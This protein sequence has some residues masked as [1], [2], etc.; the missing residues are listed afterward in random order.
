MINDSINK[1]SVYYPSAG[2]PGTPPLIHGI[3]ICTCKSAAWSLFFYIYSRI[4]TRL[5]MIRR[6]S[7]YV[8]LILFIILMAICPALRAQSE[9]RRYIKKI[10]SEH[11]LSHNIVNDIVQ[12]GKGFIW[13]ATDDGLNLFD[14]YEFKTYRFDPADSTS[15]LGNYIKSLF[16]D[17]KENLWISTRYGLNRYDPQRDI[18]LSFA[19]DWDGELDVT[20]ICASKDGGLWV[21][22]YTGGILYFNPGDG[23]FIDY[24]S[25]DP[26]FPANLTLAVHEDHEAYL[27]VGTGDDGLH[28]YR[29]N[30]GKLEA[31]KEFADKLNNLRINQVETI[32]EDTYG[33]IWIASRQGILFYHRTLHEFFHL[34]KSHGP[35]GLSGNIILD[36]NQDYMGNILI[37]TQEGGLNVLS[38]DQ[39]KANHPRAFR[40]LKILPGPED[41]HLSY[42]SV[43]TI[44]EDKDRNLWLGTFGNGI[45]L[46]PRI[47]PRFSLLKHNDLNPNSLNFDK[48][49]GLC[50]DKEGNLWIGTDGMGLNKYNLNT[51]EVTHYRAGGD[52]GDISDDAILS[53]LCDIKGRLWFGTYAGGLNLYQKETDSFTHIPLKDEAGGV[54]VNDIRAVYESEGGEIWVGSNGAGVIRF[55]ADDFSFENLVLSSGGILANDIRAITEDRE[56]GLWFGTYGTGL[57]YYHPGTKEI[58]HFAYDRVNPGTLKCNIIYALL[59]DE[60]KNQLWIGGSQNGGLNRLDLDHLTFSV[61]DHNMGLANN[62]IHAIE[63]DRRGRLWMSTNTG[64]TLFNPEDQEFTN[65]DKLDGV[66]EKEFSNGSAMRSTLH[67]LIFFGGSAG[68]NYFNADE[69]EKKDNEVPV[70]ITELKIFNESVPVRSEKKSESP[71][72]NT[73]QYTTDLKLNHRQN[74]ITIGFAGL[75]FSNPGKIKYQYTLEHADQEWKNLELQRNVTFQ[76]LRAGEYQL[77]VRAS[78]E[79]G[80]WSDGY[81]SLN[82]TI[83]PPPWRSWWAFSL[84]GLILLSFV[85]WI[86]YYNLKEA[87][88]RHKLL[89]EKKLRAQEHDLYEERI[90]FFTNISHELRTPLMLLINPLEELMTRESI[91]TVLGHKLNIMYRSANSL[92]QMIN[93][94]LEFRK[95]ETGKQKLSAA[96]YN[97]VELVEENSIAFRGMSA[98]K[99]IDI[100]FSSDDKI[101]ETWVDPEKMEMILNN[102]L[103]NAIKN[104]FENSCIYVELKK[105]QD[106]SPES[107]CGRVCIMIRDEG[108][109]IPEEE[110]DK[111]FDRFYQIK[112]AN[113]PGGT[114]IGLALTKRLVELHKGTIKVES[115]VN[116]GTTFFIW[117]PL[118][119]DHFSEEELSSG[120]QETTTVMSAYLDRQYVDTVSMLLEKLSSLSP[121]R[122]KIL[123]IED[124]EEIRDYL[125][126]LLKDRF[127]IEEAPDG[128]TGLEKARQILPALII[129]DIMMP[130]M[131]GLELCRKLKSEIETSH[132]PILMITANLA[133][134]VHIN[135]FEVGADAFITKPFKPDLLLSRIYNLLKSRKKL[136]E[137]Y[138]NQF[139]SGAVLENRSLNKDEEF[140]VRVKGLIHQHLNNSDFSIGLLHESLGMSR[141]VFYNKIRSLTN[142]APIDLVRHIRLR[143]AAEL[144]ST[145]EYKVF[146]AM[147]EVGFNDE[148][149]FRQLFKKQFGVVPSEYHK[150]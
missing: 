100:V 7:P 50:E 22:N 63:K 24:N 92:M 65:Y 140:L 52:P 93:T 29:N 66:Q 110:I 16:V 121:D 61:F 130:E 97:L 84:Y 129:S 44:Y 49:W 10:N 90:R 118:G 19:P 89:L 42:R 128:I 25:G 102:V 123:V 47:P 62:I 127:I 32:F 111:V 23:S 71:L 135:S 87:K 11:G 101:I 39:L 95:T 17:E 70:I 18:F 125:S 131:D 115:E 108:K 31:C 35:E 142:L 54:K 117:L 59:Y 126:D 80:V 2:F 85:L 5:S 74:N 41:F 1:G 55:N 109:G 134:H 149:H 82:I 53:A 145:G 12:D 137:Y 148:K 69:I 83:K 104:S 64:I 68:L 81:A 40:F 28:V 143:R 124:N 107:P 72:L 57:F 103:A 8:Y 27:W 116:Q 34:Q 132:I 94:L 15:I 141:T 98:R 91:N 73:I 56:G 105:E 38:Q 43:Q 13:I 58:R 20:D 144:L 46:I 30:E 96:R 139:K 77:R 106:R 88:T 86:Y 6:H 99:H 36:I 147:L 76:N 60:E 4:I 133:H 33:H 122:S 3:I 136:R 26:S 78:N 21:S 138:L 150:N 146:E 67:D 51:G 48:V 79:D 112:G 75:H 114:G 119:K 37:G 120:I 14:G 9:L 45:N 113:S